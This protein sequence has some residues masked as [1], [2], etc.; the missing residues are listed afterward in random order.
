[1]KEP[2][3]I[4][5]K[6]FERMKLSFDDL[7]Y[8]MLLQLWCVSDFND[9]DIA[10]KCGV[11]RDKIRRLRYE[12]DFTM[13]NTEYHVELASERKLTVQEEAD[14]ILAYIFKGQKMEKVIPDK[15]MAEASR[16]M[17]KLI[18]LKQSVIQ[19]R[20]WAVLSR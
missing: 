17:Q 13:R 9:S 8:E 7:T 12:Y 3:T 19:N 11:S 20:Y 18:L 5:R 4:T 15:A 10:E 2:R 6:E 16:R 14:A 1:M